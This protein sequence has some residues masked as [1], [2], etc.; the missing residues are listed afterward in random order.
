MVTQVDSFT[1]AQ[2][3]EHAHIEHVVDTR[4]AA[5]LLGLAPTTLRN[6]SSDG[7]GPIR[8]RKVNGRL[9]WSLEDIRALNA[10][11]LPSRCRKTKAVA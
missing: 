10:G 11:E 3:R 4:T 8:P 9:R 1:L 6:W 7:D 5:G 2:L